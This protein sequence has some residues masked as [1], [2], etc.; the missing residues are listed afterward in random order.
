MN[1]ILHTVQQLWISHVT[2]TKDLFLLE[3]RRPHCS[4]TKSDQGEH[5]SNMDTETMRSTGGI[6]EVFLCLWECEWKSPHA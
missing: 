5:G 2:F 1:P 6:A 4:D 3:R